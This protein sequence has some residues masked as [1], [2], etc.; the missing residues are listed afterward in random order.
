MSEIVK[1]KEKQA[2]L[3]WRAHPHQREHER[4]GRLVRCRI[5]F[6][7]VKGRTRAVWVAYGD[8]AGTTDWLPNGYIE[9][10]AREEG[11]TWARGWNSIGARAL[12]AARML[13]SE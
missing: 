9:L 2:V 3:V 12:R 11:I 7:L 13:V 6:L 4:L 8:R 1:L 10:H 5:R